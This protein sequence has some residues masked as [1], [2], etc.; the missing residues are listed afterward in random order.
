MI[1]KTMAISFFKTEQMICV[2]EKLHFRFGLRLQIPHLRLGPRPLFQF[3]DKF[4]GVSIPRMIPG[5]FVLFN[6][7]IAIE[8]ILIL[9]KVFQ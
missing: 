1:F 7:H 8:Q 6:I 5:F 3:P 4:L 9:S 2:L